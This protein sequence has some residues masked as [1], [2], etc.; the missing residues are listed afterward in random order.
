MVAKL[1]SSSQ[2]GH[3]TRD[4]AAPLPHA[5][6]DVRALE[7]GSVVHAVS[8]HGDDLALGFESF[9]DAELVLGTDARE[10]MRFPYLAAELVGRQGFQV[11]AGND[12][13]AL[14]AY[15]AGNGQGRGRMVPRYHEHPDAGFPGAPDGIGYLRPRG[16][17][18]FDQA[19]PVQVLFTFPLAPREGEEPITLRRISLGLLLPGRTLRAGKLAALQHHLRRAFEIAHGTSFLGAGDAHELPGGV[20]GAGGDTGESRADGLWIFAASRGIA[21]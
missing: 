15:G 1:S 9:Y 13:S 18:Q 12:F 4:V 2:V 6:S 11:R 17:P 7:G 8:G 14:D 5:D 21:Q 19:E 3:L 10:Y 16:I 20:E